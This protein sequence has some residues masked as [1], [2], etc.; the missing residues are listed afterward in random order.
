[1]K[2][3][4]LTPNQSVLVDGVIFVTYVS[5]APNDPSMAIIETRTTGPMVIQ[6]ARLIPVA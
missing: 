4:E 1:M 3:K 2:P 5:D 6:K